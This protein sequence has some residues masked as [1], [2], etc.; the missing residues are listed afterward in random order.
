M[1][2]KEINDYIFY[3]IVCL[4]EDLDLCYV[5][6]TA[7]WKQ[8]HHDHKSNCYNEKSRKYNTKLYQTIRENGGWDNFKMIQVGTREQ[9]KKREAEAIEEE[10]R[11]ELRANMNSVKCYITETKKVEDR[12]KRD[13][14]RYYIKRDEIL[15]RKQNYYEENKTEILDKLKVKVECECGCMISKGCLTRHRKTDRHLEL[16]NAN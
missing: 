4:D 12:I 10:Y 15:E 16:I 8:R 2:R 6:S 5:G 13:S 7:N 11:V 14:D 3:K 9:L 1:P